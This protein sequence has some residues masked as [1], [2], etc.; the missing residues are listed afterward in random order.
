M[1][2]TLVLFLILSIHLVSANAEDQPCVAVAKPLMTLK[3]SWAE[4]SRAAAALP[5]DCFDG[6][7]GEGISDT[8]VRKGA[9]D[10]P[11]F[12]QVLAKHGASD[13]KFFLLVLRS[14][15]S[16]LNP[17]D[18]K[19]FSNLAQESCPRNLRSQCDAILV[20]ARKALADYEVPASGEKP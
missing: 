3:S 4:I 16:T 17:D 5:A 13:D 19:A 14:L 8:I 11:G 15:N 18:I 7:F 20:Q 1:S 6:Y 10:W 12:V 2:R 9:K